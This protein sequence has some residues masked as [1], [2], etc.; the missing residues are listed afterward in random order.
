MKTGCIHLEHL[1]PVWI[2]VDTVYSLKGT[3]ASTFNIFSYDKMSDFEATSIVC[4]S[5][6]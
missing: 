3:L 2:T 6:N 5:N 1:L 4:V